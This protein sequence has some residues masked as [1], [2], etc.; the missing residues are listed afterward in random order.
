MFDFEFFYNRINLLINDASGNWRLTGFNGFTDKEIRQMSWNLLIHLSGVINLLWVCIGNYN[1]L[2]MS[3]NK[4]GR[5]EHPNL[6]SE[7]PR[8]SE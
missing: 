4:R 7:I 5:V 3:A 1:D 8:C 6:A 2:L